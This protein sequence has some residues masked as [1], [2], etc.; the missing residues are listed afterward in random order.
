MVNH[1]EDR[2]NLL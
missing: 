2:G 1:A